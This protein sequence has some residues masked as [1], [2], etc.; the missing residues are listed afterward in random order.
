MGSVYGS[1]FAKLEARQVVVP[2]LETAIM[3][4]TWPD[5]YPIVVDSSP[6]YGSLALDADMSIFK[7]ARRG[8]AGD[9]LFHPSTHA[10]MDER[11]LYYHFHPDHY[12]HLMHEKWSMQS[13]MA[14]TV[15]TAMHAI[16]Q[17][18]F[19]MLGW[20]SESNTE[21][22]FID[23]VHMARGRLDC[24]LTGH[25]TEDVIPLELKSITHRM[26]D[27]QMEIGIKPSWDAQFSIC[28]DQLG[29]DSG[30]LLMFEIGQPFR[31]HEF[32]VTKNQQLVDETYAKWDRVR[33]AIARDT[34]P[35]HCC[36]L[37]SARMRK[38]AARFECYGATA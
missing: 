31:M 8:G 27:K 33:E 38:C 36:A 25:P 30:I 7:E 2:A 4:E 37:D 26:F 11:E 22:E 14:V 5:S 9:G 24:V 16:F 34:P 21:A 6:Y 13:I 28:L 29:Y 35:R 19:Q 23:K 18:Q 15:G 20:L 12:A 10:L 1:I 3:S 17:T 32:R